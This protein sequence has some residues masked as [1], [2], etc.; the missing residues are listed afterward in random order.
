MKASDISDRDV[1]EFLAG[2]QGHWSTWGVGYSIMP[3]VQDAMPLGTPEK[4]QL[5]KMRQLHKRGFVGGCTCGC[6]GDWEITDKGLAFI[7]RERTVRY[8]GYG[9]V[10]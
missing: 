9:E 6:R 2:H 3:T 1:L 7:G 8:N 10:E 5:A 4:V